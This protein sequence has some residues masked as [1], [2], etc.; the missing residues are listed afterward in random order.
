[1]S[2]DIWS[3]FLSL[4]SDLIDTS[5]YVHF[6]QENFGT[7]S[8]QYSKIILAS[9]SEFESVSK[10]FIRSLY[11]D[12]NPSNIGDIK[13]S[14][15]TK[16][17]KIHKNIVTIASYR[18]EVKP[19]LNWANEGRLGWWDAYTNIKHDRNKNF[20]EANLQ[21]ALSSLSALLVL[22][23]YYYRCLHNYKHLSGNKLL[24]MS[25][26]GETLIAAPSNDLPDEIKAT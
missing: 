13:E 24:A 21:N 22:N 23:V 3:F 9:A 11:P 8:S 15:L 12:K 18:I 16:F 4:E 25:G 5:K 10:K 6:S 1:M 17:P 19:F 20:K 2:F 14:L 7:F 26:M